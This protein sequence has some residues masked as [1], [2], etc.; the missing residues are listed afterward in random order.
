MT[1]QRFLPSLAQLPRPLFA[2]AE[3]LAAGSFTAP[4]AHP[5]VQF[6]YAAQGV[7]EIRTEQ[8]N[9]VAPP[10]RAV[11]IPKDLAHEVRTVAKALMRSLYIAPEA[12]PFAVARCKVVEVSPL[13]RELILAFSRFPPDYD[14]KGAQGRLG[15]VLVDV[16]GGL[17][18]V[19]LSLPLPRDARLTGLCAAWLAKPETGC[20]QAGLADK[21]HLSGRTLSRLFRRETGLSVRQWCLRARLLSALPALERGESVT[22]VAL[23]AGYASTSAFIA[24]FKAQLGST[25]GEFFKQPQPSVDSEAK[26]G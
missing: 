4:H 5:W 19:A 25:P 2:R 18:E 26:P 14:A 9:F 23:D 1:S 17:P 22:A 24:A 7:L 3:E 12:L 20:S 15:R 16:L 8:G 13:A 10:K 21:A 11:W 6:S